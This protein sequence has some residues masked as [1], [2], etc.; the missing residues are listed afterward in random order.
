M[1]K[2][3]SLRLIAGLIVFAGLLYSCSDEKVKKNQSYEF[4][5]VSL[6]DT[7]PF[8]TTQNLKGGVYFFDEKN[9]VLKYADN[10]NGGPVD[11]VVV[12]REHQQY[13]TTHPHATEAVNFT[14][15][16]IG[17]FYN[18]VLKAAAIDHVT[19]DSFRVKFLVY[20]TIPIIN[21]VSRPDYVGRESAA[22]VAISAGKEYT[23]T[24][25][26]YDIR[27]RN[28]GTLCPVCQ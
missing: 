11:P 3:R 1:K 2:N 27:P 25:S 15:Y 6:K 8:T 10:I 5:I 14:L 21:G 26:V 22:I 9:K 20:D 17:G 28:L 24:S 23:T 19:V 4:R 16:D 7:I 18:D 13:K 12:E